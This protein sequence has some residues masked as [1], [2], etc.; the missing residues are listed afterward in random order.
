MAK[1][2]VYRSRIEKVSEGTRALIIYGDNVYKFGS[3]AHSVIQGD[4]WNDHMGKIIMNDLIKARLERDIVLYDPQFRTLRDNL[5]EHIGESLYSDIR[6]LVP[7]ANEM[8]DLLP[9][10]DE[11]DPN[12][13]PNDFVALMA[14]IY[15]E[16]VR[17]GDY[18]VELTNTFSNAFAHV[19][20]L[21]AGEI[22]PEKPTRWKRFLAWYERSF[23][24]EPE[25]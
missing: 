8:H 24:G 5:P 16:C 23:T 6:A 17:I 3:L 4:P 11:T 20:R 2:N 12:N 22:E 10:I 15:L 1:L 25:Y 9:L 18:V 19:D 14:S 13:F 21:M 7:L